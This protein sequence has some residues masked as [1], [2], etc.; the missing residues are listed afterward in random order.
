VIKSKNRGVSAS[1]GIDKRGVK[2]YWT[3]YMRKNKINKN[4]DK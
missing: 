4:R 2:E 1:S 3:I